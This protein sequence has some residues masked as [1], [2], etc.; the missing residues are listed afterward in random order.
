VDGARGAAAARLL[1]TDHHGGAVPAAL[2]PRVRNPRQ[3]GIRSCGSTCSGFSGTPRSTSS[4]C[5]RS[6]S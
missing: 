2:R 5:P 6:G 4:S 1:A 3:A